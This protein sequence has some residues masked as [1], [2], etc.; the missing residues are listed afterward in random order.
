MIDLEVG[1]TFEETDDDGKVTKYR[2]T[3]KETQ[4]MT[5]IITTEIIDDEG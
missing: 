1:D 4:G 2:V 5:T 3:D